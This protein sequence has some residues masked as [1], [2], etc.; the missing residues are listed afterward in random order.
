M[1]PTRWIAG[2]AS[3]ALLCIACG[4]SGSGS[5]TEQPSAPVAQEDNRTVTRVDFSKD[6]PPVI[7]T[8]T[9]PRP[10]PGE[11]QAR[12]V[13][14]DFTCASGDFALWDS[15]TC[16]GNEICFTGTFSWFDF[17]AV[18]YKYPPPGAPNHHPCLE[19]WNAVESV[20]WTGG[21]PDSDARVGP[22]ESSYATVY[23]PS[24]SCNAIGESYSSY[25]YL[26]PFD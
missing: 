21:V 6:R 25:I 13:T 10:V 18:C 9:I 2:T 3:A 1:K 11:V 16:S 26:D 7:T 15:S 19:Y 20:W 12:S 24:S 5:A 23:T 4:S 8:A 17:G 14:Q 22:S